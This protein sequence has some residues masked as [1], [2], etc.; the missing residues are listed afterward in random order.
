MIVYLASP[1]TH[2]NQEVMQR[3]Y[4]AACQAAAALMQRG[5]TV[6]A[7]IPHSHAIVVDGD[8]NE[9]TQTDFQFWMDQDLPV[10]KRCDALYVLMLPGWKISR[11]VTREIQ[12]AREHNIPVSYWYLNCQVREPDS[13]GVRA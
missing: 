2:E 3:R 8:L 6:F 1:Y 4:R 12:V 9:Q 5:L 7:P 11:G 13:A 10:L